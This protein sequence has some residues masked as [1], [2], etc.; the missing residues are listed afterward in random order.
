MGELSWQEKERA[1]E[2]E[3]TQ[4]QHSLIH[5]EEKRHVQ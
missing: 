1:K 2:K 5:T 4:R 3:A